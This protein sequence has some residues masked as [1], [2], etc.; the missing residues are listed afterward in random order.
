MRYRVSLL[1]GGSSISSE[2]VVFGGGCFWCTE[3]VFQ[4]INGVVSVEPGYAG[5]GD[6]APTYYDVAQ[7]GSDHAEVVRVTYSPEELSFNDLLS[8]F[9]ATHDP[10]SVNRQA[11]DVGPAYRSLILTTIPAQYDQALAYIEMLNESS[12]PGK[13]IVTKVEMLRT[14]YPAEPYHRNYYNNK[15]NRYCQ[16]IIN[17]KLELARKRFNHLLSEQQLG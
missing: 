16:V 14:F 8:I 1:R 7:G 5:G 10:T 3:A 6:D 15:D 11:Y 17:P 2:Q 4:R 13:P 9:F 12:R